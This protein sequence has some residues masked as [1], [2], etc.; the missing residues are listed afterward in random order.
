MI[1]V[2]EANR[3]RWKGPEGH[4]ESIDIIRRHQAAC[5]LQL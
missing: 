4:T 1:E 5:S 2:R 3:A